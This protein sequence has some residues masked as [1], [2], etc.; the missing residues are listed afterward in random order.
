M[1][2]RR[3]RS[4]LVLLAACGALP[5]ASAGAVV[6]PR[7]VATGTGVP[8][9]GPQLAGG[10]DVVYAFGAAAQLWDAGSGQTAAAP[11]VPVADGTR[12]SGTRAAWLTGG[13]VQTGP[14][15]GGAFATL[16]V[17][18]CAG[19]AQDLSLTGDVLAWVATGCTGDPERVVAQG[20][21]VDGAPRVLATG[22]G[23]RQ[24][25]VAGPWI[26]YVRG[27]SAGVGDTAVVAERSGGTVLYTLPMNVTTSIAGFLVGDDARAVVTTIGVG[28]SPLVSS[29]VPSN[30]S[31][32]AI[33]PGRALR[34]AAGH[35]LVETV[36]SGGATLSVV[37]LDSS[38]TVV[39]DFS[40]AAQRVG[41]A[42]YDG[43]GVTWAQAEPARAA[44]KAR[45]RACSRK[46]RKAKRC[47]KPIPGKAAVPAR[48]VV[49]TA[50]AR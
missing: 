7:V 26:S 20:I 46:Q 28:G 33:G 40:S 41:D 34:L 48:T 1:L 13:S 37:G 44:V 21:G 30:P 31:P 24:P 15:T 22:S 11:G 45:K 12:V 49:E 35:A 3:A 36:S 5:V 8:A 47:P 39:Q 16:P 43:T 29:V 25:I 17:D 4:A 2:R 14:I 9:L 18:G 19:P 23:L 32:F 50:V 42:D 6:T 38:T 27:G 10:G